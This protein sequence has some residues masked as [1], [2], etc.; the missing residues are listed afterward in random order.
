MKTNPQNGHA[1]PLE[2]EATP[3]GLGFYPI[4]RIT[5]G[6]ENI[7]KL[8]VCVCKP[9]HCFCAQRG[10]GAAPGSACASGKA[11][12]C[13]SIKRP[14]ASVAPDDK[15]DSPSPCPRPPWHGRH[16][17]AEA[18]G[19]VAVPGAEGRAL[20]GLTVAWQGFTSAPSLN[21]EPNPSA[22]PL[23]S[24]HQGGENSAHLKGPA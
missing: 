11:G 2:I 8:C 17:G 22:H 3:P 16:S 15:G 21:A 5:H 1:Q 9:G 12:L 13:C 20:Q 19:A 4:W 7:P 6:F 18:E 23:P 14:P 10:G 24:L